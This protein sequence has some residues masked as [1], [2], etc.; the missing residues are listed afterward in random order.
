MANYATL[1]YRI[2]GSQEELKKFN[3]AISEAD[4]NCKY[5]TWMKDVKEHLG[6]PDGEP[7]F[8]GY[9][10]DHELEDGLLSMSMEWAWWQDDNFCDWLKELFPSFDITWIGE[11]PGMVIYCTNDFEGKYFDTKYKIDWEIND[12]GDTEYFSE[13]EQLIEYIKKNIQPALN[14]D[15]DLPDD[16]SELCD[17]LERVFDAEESDGYISIDE[18]EYCEE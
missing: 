2:T 3:D 6:L 11:E 5:D 14:Q 8:R 16:F 7:Y 12:C 18:Y 9:V 4:K 15:L 13:Y 17:F 1:D 10:T